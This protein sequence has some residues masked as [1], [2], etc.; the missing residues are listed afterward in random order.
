MTT[1]STIARD[2][3]TQAYN[4]GWWGGGV[5]HYLRRRPGERYFGLGERAGA[6]DRARP[7]LSAEPHRR[8]GLRRADLRSALQA[9]PVLHHAERRRRGRP[10]ASSTT[11]CRTARSTSAASA[12]TT[13]ASIRGFA[14]EHGDLDYYVI[15]GPTRGRRHPPLHLADRPAGLPAALGPRLFRLDH[16]LYRRARRPGA[17]GRVPRRLRRA[18]HPLSI[19]FHLSSGY[20]SIGDAAATSSHWNRDKFPDPPAFAAELSRSAA[21]GCAPTSSP[22]CCADHPLFDEA[23]ARGPADLRRRRRAGLGAVLGRAR[24]LS[25][26]HQPG[27]ARLVAGACDGQPAGL[28]HR[29][30][31]ERQQR[32]RDPVAGRAGATASASPFRPR[33]AQAA[34]D[35]VDD[36]RVSRDAQIA[37]APGQAAVPGHPRRARPGCSATPRPGPATIP[38]LGDAAG[39][40]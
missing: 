8:D 33:E 38:P 36:A 20:T 35:P 15:A 28:R 32:V 13:T 14:A 39:T 1:G 6:M 5:S 12:T 18:R 24:R 3:P 21:C 37:H 10:S 2:R 34:A 9:H 27:D 4:F 7:A 16:G 29:R 40:I 30:D 26:L 23:Q 31:L 17:D 11:P 22:A 25:R 19:S